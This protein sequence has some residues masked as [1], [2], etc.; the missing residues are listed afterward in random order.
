MAFV[1]CITASANTVVPR[2]KFNPHG[3]PYW[4]GE[5]K[6]AHAQERRMRGIWVKALSHQ[7]AFP[8][9]VHGVVKFMESP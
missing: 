3:K 7:A 8:R 9:R 1:K 6:E 4:T 2:S 5:V